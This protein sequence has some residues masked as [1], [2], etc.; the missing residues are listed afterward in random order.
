MLGVAMAAGQRSLAHD[1]SR[2]DLETAEAMAGTLA[3]AE[4]AVPTVAWVEGEAAR[5][6]AVVTAPESSATA[7]RRLGWREWSRHLQERP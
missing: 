4:G 1:L 6:A 2:A 7:R 5:M 3:A